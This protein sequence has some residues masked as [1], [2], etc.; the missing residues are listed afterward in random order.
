[1]EGFDHKIA[2][3]NLAEWGRKEINLAEVEMPGISQFPSNHSFR[4]H[5][6]PFRIW[7]S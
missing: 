6:L 4:S 5:G 1:M 3:I 7:C 2:D